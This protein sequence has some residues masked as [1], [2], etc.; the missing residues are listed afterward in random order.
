[1]D[2]KHAFVDEYGAFGY[3]FASDGCS[4]HFIIC[5]I[6]VDDTDLSNVTTE[7]E[8][9]RR[10][11]FQQGEIKSSKVGINH[12]RRINI[13]NELKRLPFGIFV[14]VCDK[15]EIFE[16]SGLR[17]KQSFY[18]FINNIVYQELRTAYPKLVITAD[19]I[20]G[21]DFITSFAKYVRSKEIPLSLFDESLFRFQN[22]KDSVITQVADLVCGSL[23]YNFDAKKK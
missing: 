20:G 10:K 21:N 14:L 16:Q 1:M 9:I 17:Y 23:A 7:V 4:T 15:R 18:K 5:A 3:D 2:G 13:L 11:Y 6:I 12:I 8:A 19:E 22:S